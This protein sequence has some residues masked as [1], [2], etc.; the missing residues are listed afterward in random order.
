MCFSLS[1]ELNQIVARFANGCLS[2]LPQR[3]YMTCAYLCKEEYTLSHCVYTVLYVSISCTLLSGCFAL[4]KG[5]SLPA[6]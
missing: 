5:D 3:A 2:L 1:S 4:E 6:D